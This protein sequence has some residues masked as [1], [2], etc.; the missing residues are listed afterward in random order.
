MQRKIG[1]EQWVKLMNK[2]IEKYQPGDLIPHF[3]MRKMLFIETPNYND[4]ETQ[5]E[6]V[7]AIQLMQ[8]EYMS[9]VEKLRTDILDTHKLYLKN[10]RG[11]GY[12]FLPTN[13]QTDYAK[14]RTMDGIRKEM[15]RGI[16]IMQN[17]RFAALTQEQ[18]KSNADELAKIAQLQHL[19][20]A[21]K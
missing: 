7:E 19:M 14:Q 20:K 9:L 15:K 12:A 11:D 4:F 10:V 5:Y 13:E 2:L 18:K 8:F 21:F 3:V 1:E 17:I 16:T 6:F